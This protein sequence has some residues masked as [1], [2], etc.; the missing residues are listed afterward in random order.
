MTAKA[1]CILSA[2]EEKMVL[3]AE[4][5]AIPPLVALLQNGST[6]KSKSNAAAALYT[7]S[8]NKDNRVAIARAGAIPALVLVLQERSDDD[9]D[10]H[11]IIDGWIT[12]YDDPPPGVREA[13]MLL[14]SL[15]YD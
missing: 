13:L 8:D 6:D 10:S 12:H 11:V 1:L 14:R 5:G 3:I 4:A 15:S 7:L 9:D 2:N